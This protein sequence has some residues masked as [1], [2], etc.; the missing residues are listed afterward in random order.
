[1]CRSEISPCSCRSETLRPFFG[2]HTLGSKLPLPHSAIISFLRLVCIPSSGC[3]GPRWSRAVDQS[4]VTSPPVVL[5][6]WQES[7]GWSVCLFGVGI[8]CRSLSGS[9]LRSRS[10]CHDRWHWPTFSL[11]KGQAGLRCCLRHPI[12]DGQ[13][14]P[15]RG[16]DLRRLLG[17]CQLV[18]T[19]WGEAT[20]L[21]VHICGDQTGQR[22]LSDG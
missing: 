4:V 19:E 14:D 20:I 6:R 1:M 22:R 9:M 17:F 18:V 11:Q 21:P 12:L 8:E 3:L 5:L 13:T 2:M 7:S 10:E 16:F 15:H